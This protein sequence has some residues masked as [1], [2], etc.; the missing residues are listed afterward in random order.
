M[1]TFFPETD[2]VC[3]ESSFLSSFRFWQSTCTFN[4]QKFCRFDFVF[5]PTIKK[6]DEE[7]KRYLC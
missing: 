7:V 1:S 4:G 5:F 6:Y 2:P 3:G